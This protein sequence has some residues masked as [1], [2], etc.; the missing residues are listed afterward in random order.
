MARAN[1]RCGYLSGRASRR[2]RAGPDRP[3]SLRPLLPR[4][5]LRRP[6]HRPTRPG[7]RS[8]WPGR[9]RAV[10][11]D[12][13]E[14]DGR[15]VERHAHVVRR[16]EGR[17]PV[18]IA[19]GVEPHPGHREGAVHG[20][21]VHRLVVVP[22]QRDAHLGADDDRPLPSLRRTG[23]RGAAHPVGQAL[24][25]REWA[26]LHVPVAVRTSV[27]AP[28]GLR[29]TRRVARRPLHPHPLTGLDRPRAD[30]ED[31]RSPPDGSCGCLG[32]SAARCQTFTTTV[33][34]ARTRR[35]RAAEGG[36]SGSWRGRPS[37]R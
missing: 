22:E 1:E 5:G 25:A 10:G 24:T 2:G 29:P 4:A 6:F 16:R 32:V 34:R 15:E 11:L 13:L 21:A 37:S 19:Q 33:R 18:V 9:T 12:L 17:H 20:R 8:G 35:R 36:R 27:L 31:T 7:R 14:E 3:P 23:R 28:R 26:Q 30:R